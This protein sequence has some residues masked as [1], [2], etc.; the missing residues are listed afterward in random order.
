[1]NSTVLIKGEQFP[2]QLLNEHDVRAII[3]LQDRVAEALQTK[4]HL[5]KLTVQEIEEIIVQRL[6]AG[7]FAGEM[8]IAARAFY[9]QS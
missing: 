1:M 8:L 9:S 5:Q 7:V 6:F 4:E 3:Q 2:M